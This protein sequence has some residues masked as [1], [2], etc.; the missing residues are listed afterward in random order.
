M[1][2]ST[3]TRWVVLIAAILGCLSEVVQG[4]DRL[5]HSS[6]GNWGKLFQA[7]APKLGA[8]FPVFRLGVFDPLAS[9][10]FLLLL[11]FGV[12]HFFTGGRLR[13]P[14]LL[15]LSLIWFSSLMG[16]LWIPAYMV[17]CFCPRLKPPSF[18]RA[19]F[20]QQA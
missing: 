3:K 20:S 10:G 9:C 6:L 2:W 14:T 12:R 13:G 19:A 7:M 17:Y 16:M 1:T 8:D 11:V 18:R 4:L 5:T 15:V